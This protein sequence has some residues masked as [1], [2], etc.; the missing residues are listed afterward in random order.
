MRIVLVTQWY[1]PEPAKLLADWAESLTEMGHDVTVLTGFPNYPSG[2]LYPGFRLAAW[3]REVVNGVS[4]VRVPL[5]PSHDASAIRRIINYASFALSASLLGPLLIRRPHVVHVLLN[6]LT[7]IWPAWVISRLFRVPL[8]CEVQDIWPETLAA[9]GMIQNRWALALVGAFANWSYRRASAIRVISRGF[10][11]N[12]QSKGVHA[13]T[14]HIIPNSVDVPDSESISP[15]PDLAQQLS[16]TGRFTVMFAGNMGPAQDLANVLEAAALLRKFPQ[17]QIALVGD[18]VD[19]QRLRQIKRERSL[20]N[21]H[22]LGRYPVDKMPHLYALA[23]VLLVHLRD[24]PLFRITIPHKTYSYM[25]SGKPVLAAVEGDVADTIERSGAGIA[26]RAGHPK[27]LADAI[28]HLYSMSPDQR[29]VMA[30]NGRYAVRNSFSRE[31]VVGQLATMLAAAVN[32]RKEKNTKVVTESPA[33]GR[34]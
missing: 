17:V 23:D 14:L 24:D 3:R 31:T 32:A 33:Q 30:D 26:C 21:V 16:L 20:S 13:D 34:N 27:A 1:P 19:L 10:F 12:L 4:V 11:S 5:Y 8:T 22:F 2:K 28:L 9:T 15:D 25:A 18:G 6:P 29:R 7:A